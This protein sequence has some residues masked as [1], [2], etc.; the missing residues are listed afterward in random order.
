M[1]LRASAGAVEELLARLC[2]PGLEIRDIH[3]PAI[4]FERLRLHLGVVDEGD[5]GG[6][7]GSGSLNGGMPFSGRPLWMT[8]AILSPRTS[9]ATSADRVKS[10]PVSP[11]I[12]SRPW[13][14]P[15]WEAN[16]RASLHLLGRIRLRRHG[17]R[18]PLRCRAAGAALP[19]VSSTSARWRLCAPTACRRLRRP[20]WRHGACA[21]A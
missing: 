3:A 19:L 4:A 11:P 2:V 7:V 18:R 5:D 1:A 8:G 6:D 10:G 12:A 14:N 13:Q 15:H 21:C 20:G 16:T 9:S 17:L